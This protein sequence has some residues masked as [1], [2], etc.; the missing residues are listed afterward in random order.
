MDSC[1]SSPPKSRNGRSEGFHGFHSAY[2]HVRSLGAPE[3]IQV[4]SQ[5]FSNQIGAS[6][7]LALGNEINLFEHSWWQRDEHLLGHN[8]NPREWK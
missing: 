7:V 5:G 1:F 3:I 8:A 4:T 6:S 2:S